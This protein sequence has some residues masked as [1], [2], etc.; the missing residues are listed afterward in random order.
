MDTIDIYFS[1]IH[2]LGAWD[3]LVYCVFSPSRIVNINF[4]F[5]VMHGRP[6]EIKEGSVV[7][8]NGMFLYNYSTCVLQF[9]NVFEV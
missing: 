7:L 2:V 9:I 6:A 4:I 5:W 3:V 8:V 1:T